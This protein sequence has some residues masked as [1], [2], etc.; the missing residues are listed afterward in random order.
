MKVVEKFLLG[1]RPNQSLCEDMIVETPNFIGV[2][3]GVTSKNDLL[4]QNGERKVSGGVKATLLLKEVI[5]NLDKNACVEEFLKQVTLKF[6]S[7]Y[8][9]AGLYEYLKKKVNHKARCQSCLALYSLNRKEVWLFGDC[10]IKIDGKQFIKESGLEDAE[11]IYSKARALYLE[12]ELEEGKT[13]E[14]LLEKDTGRD[15]IMPLIKKYSQFSNDGKSP[16]GYCVIDGFDIPL[17]L[18]EVIDAKEGKEIIL[19]SDGYPV[20]SNTLEESE[21]ILK[22]QLELDPLCFREN[23]RP[24]ALNKGYNS[25]DDRCYIRFQI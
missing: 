4:W 10:Q 6:A 17:N 12:C 25:F 5:E 22:E 21:K 20:V 9:E 24:K 16:L 18:V 7:C 14:Q 1:K 13:I 11:M 3:D 15:F 19:A 23:P 8:K 2:L